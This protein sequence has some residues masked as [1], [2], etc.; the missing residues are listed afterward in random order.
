[1]NLILCETEPVKIQK[2]VK[3]TEEP[4]KMAVEESDERIYFDLDE[5]ITDTKSEN[6]ADDTIIEHVSNYETDSLDGNIDPATND[7]IDQ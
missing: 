3:L 1:M 5:T 6:D 7:L 2:A 4:E